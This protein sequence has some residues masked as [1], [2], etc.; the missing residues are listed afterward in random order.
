MSARTAGLVGLT[1]TVAALALAAPGL[2]GGNKF[3]TVT[4]SR[5]CGNGDTVALNGPLKLWP[6]NHKMVDEPVT[7]TDASGDQVTLTLTPSVTDA[8]GGD[9]GPTHDPD[10]QLADGTTGDTFTATGSGSATAALQLRAERSG[11]GDGRTYTIGWTA[12][13]DNGSKSCASTDSGQTPF[14][15]T[16]PH[17]MR[18]GASWK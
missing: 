2:A 13:F 3:A 14:T 12:T 5:D 16:V 10:W 15:I 7:A 1:A 4:D 8:T 11:K 17:D 18:G 9:G 6:P